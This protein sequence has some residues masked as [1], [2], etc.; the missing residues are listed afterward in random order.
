MNGMFEAASHLGLEL[1]SEMMRNP[2]F[3]IARFR[4]GCFQAS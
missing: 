1:K 4:R 3:I 2:K